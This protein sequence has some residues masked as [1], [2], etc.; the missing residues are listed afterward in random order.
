M[1]IHLTVFLVVLFISSPAR[2]QNEGDSIFQAPYI[3]EIYMTFSQPAYWD[4]LTA[5]YTSDQYL[6]CDLVINGVSYDSAGVKFKGNSSYSGPGS[7]K[8]FKV[9]LNEY[10]SGQNINGLKKFNLNN[11]FKDPS[12]LREKLVCD[13]YHEHGIPAP[14]CT[15]AKVY[16]N[17]TY[18]GLYNII[19]EVDTKTYLENNFVEN[20][21]NIFKGD[22]FGDLK[23]LGNNDSN[24]YSKYELHSNET[25]NDW[26]DLVHLIDKINNSGSSF[27]D[28]LE[29]VLNTQN[30]IKQ[31]AA[32]QLFVNLDSYIGSGHNYYIYHSLITDRFE[33]IAWD[34]NES[35]GNF[36]MGMTPSQLVSLNFLYA[37][38]PTGSRPLTQKMLTNSFYISELANTLCSWIQ[39]DFSNATLDAK[40]DSIANVIRPAVYADT[41]K[42]YTNQNFEDNLSMD[43]TTSGP[44]GGGTIMG[45]KS[46]IDTRR[47]SLLYQLSSYA[48]VNTTVSENQSP[49]I[50]IYPNPAKTFFQINLS[51]FGEKYKIKV[52]NSLGQTVHEMNTISQS[53]VVDVSDFENGIYFV[54]INGNPSGKVSV[55]N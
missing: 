38:N 52:I 41:K 30:F 35:F 9:D 1:K 25:V 4:S 5:Y 18:W 53:E 47:N 49:G 36:R 48:C 44:G 15:Y 24:Y 21:G 20:D 32:L 22:P 11:I 12:F 19:E 17:G 8:P 37:S 31:W 42:A 29:S 13:F 55:V 43:I 54:L 7:K 45:I 10:T 51:A 26:S 39:N 46:F 3:H 16:I 50:R 33:W 34:L 6:S 40:I 23:W 28:S 14:R 27:Y 2:A